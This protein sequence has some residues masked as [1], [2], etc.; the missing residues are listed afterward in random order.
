MSKLLK[1]LRASVAVDEQALQTALRRQQIYGGSLDTV[2]LELEL[3]DPATLG[4]LLERA[5]GFPIVP[6]ELLDNGLV[7]PWSDIPESMQRS[8]WVEPR[9]GCQRWAC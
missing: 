8:R 4:D 3:L 7:R 1:Q 6:P 9:G 5:C 2:L